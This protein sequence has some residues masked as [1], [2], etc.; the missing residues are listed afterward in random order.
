MTARIPK[1]LRTARRRVG[2]VGALSAHGATFPL[3]LLAP[4]TSREEM[5]VGAMPAND[6][7]QIVLT[8]MAIVAFGALTGIEAPKVPLGEPTPWMGLFERVLF[9]AWLLWLSVLAIALLRGPGPKPS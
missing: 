1:P 7:R 5:R 9:A 8:V 3:W 2:C 6:V 4:M